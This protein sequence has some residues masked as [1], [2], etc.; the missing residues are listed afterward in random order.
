MELL[1]RGTAQPGF[2][3][4]FERDLKFIKFGVLSLKQ[5]E[6][7]TFKT[8]GEEACF[9]LL[10]GRCD[11]AVGER[12]FGEIGKRRSVFEGRPYSVYVPRNSSLSVK[13]KTDINAA[14]CTAPC[15]SNREPALVSPDQVR[16]R[17]VGRW[18][19]RRDVCDI[20]GNE[21]TIPE[22]L[23]V[24]ET[25][26]PP[27]NW[28]SAPPHKH[29]VSDLPRESKLEEVYFYKLNPP[30]GFALQRVYTQDGELDEAF[31]VRDGDA[32][33]I[34]KGYHPVVAAPGYSLYY[35]WV[36]AGEER[37][38]RPNDDPDHAWLKNCEGIIAEIGRT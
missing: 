1:K 23:I 2:R 22:K 14:I 36:L 16:C 8:K 38:M 11:A 6:E 33:S 28:S 18:N 3:W 34:P 32:I 20:M 35:L 27:G 24:G 19:W 13:A 7:H 30:Q 5:G 12:D 4:M 9:V 26:N 29:D 10:A 21:S 31:V 37:V 25:F 17:S 15:E